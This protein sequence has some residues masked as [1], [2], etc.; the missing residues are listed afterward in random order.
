MVAIS[1]KARMRMG[2]LCRLRRL[3]DDGNMKQMYTSFIRP[4]M[5][6]GSVQF[7][8]AAPEH[9]KKLDAV[10][11]SAERIGHFE[12]ESLQS[13]REATAVAFTLKLLDGA[14]R[15]VLKNHVPTLITQKSNKDYDSR[16][17]PRPL[18]IADRTN[19]NSLYIFIRSYLGCIHKIWARLP[20]WLLEK[21]Q[22]IRCR[23]ISKQCKHI[24]TGK[25]LSLNKVNSR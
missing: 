1:K 18:Q 14:G 25:T 2:M 23:T 24:I 9:L 5:E 19:T 10:Q 12:I 16:I 4:V 7:M 21:G 13:R 6:Y 11:R 22:V 17:G 20:I 15:G 3:M 8:G